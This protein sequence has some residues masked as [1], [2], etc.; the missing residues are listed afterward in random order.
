MTKKYIDHADSIIRQERAIEEARG[1]LKG[2]G[3]LYP[4]VTASDDPA[5]SYGRLLAYGEQEAALIVEILRRQTAVKP[6][7]NDKIEKQ[8]EWGRSWYD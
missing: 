7:E 5:E 6:I 2:R 3:I 4:I 1:I 8:K